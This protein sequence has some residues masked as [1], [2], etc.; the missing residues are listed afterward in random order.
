MLKKI[1]PKVERCQT[2]TIRRMKPVKV[3]TNQ[4]KKDG[5]R[6]FNPILMVF[7][8]RDMK[9]KIMKEKGSWL[10]PLFIT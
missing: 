3:E 6:I 9:D 10:M 8:S 5:K 4:E 7:K 2:G 1:D